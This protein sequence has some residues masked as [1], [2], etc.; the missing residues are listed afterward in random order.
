MNLSLFTTFAAAKAE[1]SMGTV[2][3]TG[4]VVVF[5]V[6]LLLYL[7]ISLE[8]VIFTSIDKKKAAAS[9]APTA[10]PAA[11]PQTNA[12]VAARAQLAPLAAIE[13]GIPAEVV[14][15]ISAA[16]AA[17]DGGCYTIHSMA[18]AKTGRSAWGSAGVASYTEPF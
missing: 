4:I 8:G 2:V 7:I 11:A 12:P 15:A 1:P 13:Q 18:R 3:L 17:M 10:K 5:G 6:L 16:I 14:A 9:A